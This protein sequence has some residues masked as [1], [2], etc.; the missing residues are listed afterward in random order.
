MFTSISLKKG[1]PKGGGRQDGGGMANIFGET[2]SRRF[3][4]PVNVRF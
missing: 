2:K 3:Q 1:G 4:Q